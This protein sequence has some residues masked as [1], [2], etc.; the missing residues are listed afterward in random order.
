MGWEVKEELD[1]DVDIVV[2]AGETPAQPTTVIDWS[3][4]APGGRPGRRRRPGEVRGLTRFVCAAE[5]EK[6]R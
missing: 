5:P 1:N 4:P 3:E 6:S 2:E